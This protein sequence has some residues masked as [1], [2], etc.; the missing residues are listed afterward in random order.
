[1]YRIYVPSYYHIVYLC[2]INFEFSNL[3]SLSQLG[4]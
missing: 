4:G 2:T 3:H 1:M